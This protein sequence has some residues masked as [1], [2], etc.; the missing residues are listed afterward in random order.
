MPRK[1]TFVSSP[2]HL[3]SCTPS[4]RAEQKVGSESHISLTSNSQDNQEY[5]LKH[6]FFVS[7]SFPLGI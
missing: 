7:L 4:A 5:L 2:A 6:R 3:G 1:L